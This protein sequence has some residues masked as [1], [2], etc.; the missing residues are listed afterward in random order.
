[1]LRREQ[2]HNRPSPV[3]GD[4][5]DIFDFVLAPLALDSFCRGV[6][7][8]A[9][10]VIAALVRGM[11]EAAAQDKSSALGEESPSIFPG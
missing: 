9:H 3:E 6:R 7:V 10:D 1:M 4:E 2:H 5:V 8:D 11:V